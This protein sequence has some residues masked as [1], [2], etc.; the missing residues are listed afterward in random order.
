MLRR[1]HLHLWLVGLSL[2]IALSGPVGR[3]ARAQE[4][5]EAF[6]IT[7]VTG[8]TAAYPGEEVIFAVVAPQPAATYRWVFSDGPPPLTG[9]RVTRSFG[10]VDDY[11]V[12]LTVQSGGTETTAG[13]RVLRVIPELRGVFAS[14]W[15]GQF[16]PADLFQMVVVVNAP[17]L[18]T[19]NVRTAGA[20]VGERTARYDLSGGENWLILEDMRLAGERDPIIRE[21]LLKRPG[22]NIPLAGGMFTLALDYTTPS[23][24]EQTAGFT[25][26]VHDFFQPDRRLAVTYPRV[27]E[28]AGR[29]PPDM[30]VENYYLRGDP[31]FSHTDDYYVRLLALEFGRRGGVWPDDPH[32]VAMN[33]FRTIDALLGDDDPGEFN[34]DYNFA[35]L[36]EE[37]TLSRTTKNGNYICIAQTYLFT[38]LTRTVGMPTREINN[39]IGEPRQQRADGVWQ[40]RWW[41]EAGAEV[42]YNDAW[43]YFD[44]YY[45]VTERTAYL[46]KNLI[47]QAWNAFNQQ[48]TQFFTVRGEPTGM[49][50]HNF[51]AWPGDPPQWSFLEEVAR[52]GVRV[53]GMTGGPVAAAI[54]D[55]GEE[56]GAV[57]QPPAAGIAA[58]PQAARP[59]FDIVAGPR[60]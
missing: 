58:L 32:Q 36:W 12:M 31:D 10:T 8:G 43:H 4:G 42:W 50:G 3:D 6:T 60:E 45:A 5:G 13:T 49:R 9:A 35:R 52:P 19:L 20:L 39:A 37:G 30:E 15:D 24:R 16:T 53:E 2:I 7:P 54:T 25:P 27:W 51:Q 34:N 28:F 23:G 47:Y 22:A 17:G 41:Q 1:P 55:A 40:V 14:D 57:A 18:T 48:S 38:A 33:I 11:T 46:A 29:P 21:E 56:P 44:T 26:A 59:T